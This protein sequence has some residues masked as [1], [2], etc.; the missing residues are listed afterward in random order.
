MTER[1]SKLEGAYEQASERFAEQTQ[2]V[3]ALRAENHAEHQELRASH[4][5]LRAEVR[6]EIGNVWRE[7]AELRKEAHRQT[8]LIIGV[9]GGLMT[10]LGGLMTLSRFIA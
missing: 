9:L 7:V 2:A 10:L 8:Y 1:V 3:N 6:T 5:A 4:E